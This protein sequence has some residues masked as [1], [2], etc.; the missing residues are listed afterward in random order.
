MWNLFL[1]DERYP[2]NDGKQWI[3][4][5][6]RQDAVELLYSRGCPQFISF[7]H[8]LGLDSNNTGYAFAKDWINLVLDGKI[9]I[10]SNFNFYVHSQNPV[11]AENIRQLM[12]Q[13]IRMCSESSSI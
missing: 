2:P 4:A 13:F 10:P 7:D 5:R 1:D 11:G 12:S 8:D 3:I 9:V 6:S